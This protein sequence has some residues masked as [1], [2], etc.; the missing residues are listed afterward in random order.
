MSG[1]L[2]LQAKKYRFAL[3]KNAFECIFFCGRLK[4]IYGRRELICGSQKFEVSSLNFI[5]CQIFEWKSQPGAVQ[6]LPFPLSICLFLRNR[7]WM[8]RAKPCSCRKCS[9]NSS[10]APSHR[11]FSEWLLF[12]TSAKT[13]P[14]LSLHLFVLRLFSQF[15]VSCGFLFFLLLTLHFSFLFDTLLALSRWISSL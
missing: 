7:R 5:L 13:T 9:S 6:A 4:P 10:F 2:G 14:K 11:A 1:W 12:T 3:N 8:R 15:V